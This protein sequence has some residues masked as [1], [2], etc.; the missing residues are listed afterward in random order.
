MKAWIALSLMGCGLAS[1]ITFPVCTPVGPLEGAAGYDWKSGGYAEPLNT[2]VKNE[3]LEK[4]LVKA[5]QQG[6]IEA[7]KSQFGFECEQR[8]VVPPCNDCYVCHASL[9]KQVAPQE[10]E[11]FVDRCT[12]SGE[13][14]I[15]LEIGPGRRA[16]NAMTYWRRPPLKSAADKP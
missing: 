9:V 10:D 12:K 4:F 5:F 2:W 15:Q 1:C 7:L 3:R 8:S 6:G 16:L 13:M 14:L 11:P